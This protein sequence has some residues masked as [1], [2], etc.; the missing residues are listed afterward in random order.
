LRDAAINRTAKLRNLLSVLNRTDI[1]VDFT[2]ESSIAFAWGNDEG[3]GL[4]NFLWQ[5]I[6]A[7]EVALRLENA[8]DS[9]AEYTGGVYFQNPRFAHHLQVMA[10][11]RR[12]H[13]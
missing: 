3:M 5:I 2:K 9:D 11:Q 12:D 10:N 13:P 1:F 8:T 4:W 7:K 6:I